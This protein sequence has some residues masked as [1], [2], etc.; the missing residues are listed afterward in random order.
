MKVK[1]LFFLIKRFTASIGKI[2]PMKANV[3][4]FFCFSPS[5][6]FILLL[7]DGAIGSKIFLMS[8]LSVVIDTPTSISSNST[9]RSTSLKT[10]GERVS[11]P[12]DIET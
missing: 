11:I 1:F 8:S 7:I 10:S 2:G 3:L 6:V 4:I 5:S 12:G 9:N